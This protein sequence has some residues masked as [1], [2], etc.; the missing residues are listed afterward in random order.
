MRMYMSSSAKVVVEI[1]KQQKHPENLDIYIGFRSRSKAA[2][3]KAIVSQKTAGN[4]ESKAGA[5]QKVR[6]AAE[7]ECV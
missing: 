1:R 5:G 2:W 4:H 3:K 7:C 6:I